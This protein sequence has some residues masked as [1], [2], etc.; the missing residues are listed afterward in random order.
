MPAPGSGPLAWVGTDA[1]VLGT[2]DGNLERVPLTGQ[3]SSEPPRHEVV[4]WL[5]GL[6]FSP[7]GKLLATV[8]EER[9]PEIFHMLELWDTSSGQRVAVA[10]QKLTGSALTSTVTFIP[11]TSTLSWQGGEWVLEEGQLRRT[12]EDAG[13]TVAASSE[14]KV[15]AVAFCDVLQVQDSQGKLVREVTLEEKVYSSP[16]GRGYIDHPDHCSVALSQDGA[17][18]VSWGMGELKLWNPRS[19]NRAGDGQAG[20]APRAGLQGGLRC[21]FS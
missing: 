1:V 4:T 12:R 16:D 20:Q 7:D 6:T 10:E 9:R 15:R 14:G 19:P 5:A 17:R 8:V 21:H 2:Q 18:M 13:G 3:A 11:G